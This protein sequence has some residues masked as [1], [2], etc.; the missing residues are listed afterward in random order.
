MKKQ[1]D[2]NKNTYRQSMI[3]NI[4]MFTMYNGVYAAVTSNT[5]FLTTIKTT[6]RDIDPVIYPKNCKHV[7]H[8]ILLFIR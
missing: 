5:I 8:N 6:V 4:A 2:N 7:D 3:D 1:L